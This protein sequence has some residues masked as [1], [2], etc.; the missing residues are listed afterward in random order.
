V[1]RR[2]TARGGKK[3]FLETCVHRR[4]KFLTGYCTSRGPICRKAA[5][6]RNRT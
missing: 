5:A 4:T 6:L 3:P 2:Q 1:E